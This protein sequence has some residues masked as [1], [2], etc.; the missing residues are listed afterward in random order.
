MRYATTIITTLSLLG[1]HALCES[2]DEIHLK[3][4]LVENT[5]SSNPTL[6]SNVKSDRDLMGLKFNDLSFWSIYTTEQ[7]GSFPTASPVVGPTTPSPTRSPTR[8]PTKSP[9]ATPT[10]API[11]PGLSPTPSPTF[12]PTKAPTPTPT[13]TPTQS[14]TKAPTKTPTPP[15]T[16]APVVG[17]SPPP[18]PLPTKSPTKPPTKSPTKA[19]TKEPT[20]NPTADPTPNPTNP[21]TRT[22]T[23]PPTAAP[24]AQRVIFEAALGGADDFTDPNSYQS[25]ALART[26][27]QNGINSR[28][29]AKVI[30][31]YT[32]FCIFCATNAVPNVITDNDP[33]FENLQEF[34]G[35]TS[36]DGWIENNVD[37]CNYHGI[38]CDFSD[39]VT[40]IDLS[41]NRLTGIFPPEVKLLASDGPFSTGAGRLIQ[42]DLSTNEFVF[43]NFDT[44]WLSDTGSAMGKNTEETIT[45]DRASFLTFILILQQHPSISLS[46]LSLDFFQDFQQG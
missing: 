18:T 24:F 15:P 46:R 27:D 37:P 42:L 21:P 31:Y 43:N 32:L 5:V 20:P 34:P 26:L 11:G 23:P 45:T 3:R 22:A 9:T 41:S 4:K 39:Q 6:E 40:Q 19:P 38:I 44:S 33:R 2:A 25:C 35:W 30:Q 16:L 17:P 29:E 28:S 36:D 10:N 7:V 12:S 8:P 1:D 14:P 13:K